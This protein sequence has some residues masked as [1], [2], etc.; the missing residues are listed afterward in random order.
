M[1]KNHARRRRKEQEVSGR[2]C[3]LGDQAKE[4]G[5]VSSWKLGNGESFL[6]HDC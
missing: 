6:G 2:C 3:W 4:L 1:N 5:A